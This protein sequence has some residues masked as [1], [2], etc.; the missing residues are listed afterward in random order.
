MVAALV[1]GTS[2]ESRG[3]SSPLLG[4]SLRTIVLRLAHACQSTG[5]IVRRLARIFVR[6]GGGR[7]RLGLF[8]VYLL[9]SIGFPDQT[10]CGFTEDLK[11]R[12]KDHNAGKSKHTSKYIPWELISYHA[13]SDQRK[14]REFEHYLKTGS[15]RAF[16][17]KRL[18]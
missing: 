14:A 15:G 6:T 4:T 8:Y 16:A 5:R 1:S 17:R 11:T 18:I 13:F 2:D 3:G 7:K 10:Y 12:L 9:R